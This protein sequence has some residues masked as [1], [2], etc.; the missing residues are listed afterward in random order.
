MKT[1]QEILN[2][3]RWDEEFAKHRFAIAYYDRLQ[4]DLITVDFKELQFS[5]DDH[6][7]FYF[8]DEF[9]ETHSVPYHRI[10]AVYCDD[11]LI[12]HRD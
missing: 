3:V 4:Q 11:E 12:W 10:R 5:S 1:V 6:F 7:C 8:I 9:G 2:R